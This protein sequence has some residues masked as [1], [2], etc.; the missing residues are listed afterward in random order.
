MVGLGGRN[1]TDRSRGAMQT[2][3]EMQQEYEDVRQIKPRLERASKP[4]NP[5]PLKLAVGTL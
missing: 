4:A 2:V 5:Q 1:L 3:V